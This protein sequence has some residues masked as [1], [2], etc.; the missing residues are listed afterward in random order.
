MMAARPAPPWLLLLVTVALPQSCFGASSHSLKYFSTSI[1]DP[2]QGEQPHFVAVGYVDDQIFVHY[3]SHS[4]R[5]K[6]RVSWMEKV[7][8]EDPKYWDRNTQNVHDDEEWF[9]V[10]LGNLRIRYNQSEGLH[11]LQGMYGCELC[12]DGAKDGFFQ[13]GYEGKTFITFDKETLIWVAPD[14]QAQ[15][16]KRK[17]DAIPGKNERDKSYLEEICIEWLKKYLSYGKETLQRTE[18]P[19]V[20]VSS[21]TEVEDGM[22]THICRLDGFYPRD[23]DASWR[24]DG[25]EWLEE[26]FHGSVAPNADG[27]YHYWLSVRI[28]PK[29]RSCYRCHV[30]HDGL[31]E[32]LEL[33]LKETPKV[34]V[35]SRTE[36]EDGMETHV[37]RVDGFY[38]RDID[39]S[40]RRDGEEWLEETFHGSVAPNADGTYHYWLSIRIDPKERSRYRCH[41]EHDGLQEPLDLE[42][43]EPS[44]SKSN[45]GLIIGCVMAALVL[46]YAI[47]G[48]LVF[49]KRHQDDYK[50]AS[51]S[52]KG[53]SSSGWGSSWVIKQPLCSSPSG[54]SQQ[55][56][57]GVEG[58][59]MKKEEWTVPAGGERR[60][61]DSPSRRRE[62]RRSASLLN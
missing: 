56:E 10:S 59:S 28:D 18:P 34:T 54:Q 7:G 6:P 47:A 14:P 48:I 45:L 30:E 62:E 11:T 21:R 1:S 49:F 50:A 31:Q 55:E 22:E 43:K 27:T 35:S 57:R 24:K 40:W 8:K 39:A 29:E 60:G 46:A 51:T 23:I 13:Y 37:C 26:S 58:P 44:N 16:T 15:I 36:V 52:D 17:W 53:Y 61:V 41:V 4:Q 32:P 38:P 2:S 5:M 9:R 25:E 20:T 12:K 3:D 19:V 42:L 33:E